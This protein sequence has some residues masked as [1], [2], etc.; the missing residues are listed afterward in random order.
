[1]NAKQPLIKALRSLHGD[2]A[3]INFAIIRV[4]QIAFPI[5]LWI[6]GPGYNR[7]PILL[8]RRSSL[9]ATIFAQSLPPQS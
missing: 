8:F 5:D 6:S 7:I 3:G 4:Q 9:T 1:M 2:N